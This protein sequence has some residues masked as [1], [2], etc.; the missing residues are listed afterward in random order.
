MNKGIMILAII[1]ILLVAAGGTFYTMKTLAKKGGH[2]K[3]VEK[4]PKHIIALDERTINLADTDGSHY[5]R[6]TVA[7]EIEAKG[8]VEKASEEQK[9]KL[10]DCLIDVVGRQT[11]KMLLTVKGKAQLK[12][13]LIAGFTERLQDTKW[14]VDDVLFTDIVME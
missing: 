2:S 6:L 8:E 4:L 13:Q 11:L 1:V 9:P 3:P 10:L 5:V 12:K 14:K 7:L